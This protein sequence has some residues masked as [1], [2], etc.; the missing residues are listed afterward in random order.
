MTAE[1][2]GAGILPEENNNQPVEKKA[3]SLETWLKRI[4]TTGILCLTGVSL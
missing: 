1:K 3:L 4:Q 2:T